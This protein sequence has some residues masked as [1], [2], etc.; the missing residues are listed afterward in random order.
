MKSS[1]EKPLVIR[2]FVGTTKLLLNGRIEVPTEK[3][4]VRIM[5][6]V[7]PAKAFNADSTAE[8]RR[9][10]STVTIYTDSELFPANQM[11][12]RQADTFEWFGKTY[13]VQSISRFPNTH[14]A[15][16]EATAVEVTDH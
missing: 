1:F 11:T 2:R 3:T 4:S 13:E 9:G 10:Y 5:A 16:F 12:G 14:L 8:G 7:Q 6:S 15:H